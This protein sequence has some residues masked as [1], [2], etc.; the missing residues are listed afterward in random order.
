MIGEE[1]RSRVRARGEKVSRKRPINRLREAHGRRRFSRFPSGR[2]RGRASPARKSA[3]QRR[4]ADETGS[5]GA[6]RRATAAPWERLGVKTAARAFPAA[7]R[8]AEGPYTGGEAKQTGRASAPL[9][10]CAPDR[11][12]VV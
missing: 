5:R 4:S 6:D 12:S 8:R 10:R 3:G 9:R 7:G 1:H 2:K 11:K